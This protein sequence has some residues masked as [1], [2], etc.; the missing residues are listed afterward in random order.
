M[1]QAESFTLPSGQSVEMAVREGTNDRNVCHAIL[2]ED[3][4]HFADLDLSGHALDIGAHIGAATVALG[5]LFPDLTITAIEPVPD[6]V[7]LLRR[8]VEANGL[9][10]RVTVRHGVAGKAR[11]IAHNFRGSESAE[12]HRH[13]G[14]QTMPAGTQHDTFAAPGIPV[15]AADF[16]KI[17]CEGG[18]WDIIAALRR[19]PRFHGELHPRDG[20][21]A[22]DFAASFPHHRF[23]WYGD[24]SAACGFE[25]VRT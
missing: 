1:T 8:N 12:V 13:I 4:Y 7:D 3:E 14:N 9:A 15:P 19:I 16:A 22:V 24:T 17:D 6:N 20:K 11:P 2:V 10:E 23:T 25:A 21:G 5:I 18:E